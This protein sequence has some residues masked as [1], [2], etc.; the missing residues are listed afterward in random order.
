[1]S[2]NYQGKNDGWMYIFQLRLN[3]AGKFWAVP[4]K[5]LTSPNSKVGPYPI[6]WLDKNHRRD[7]NGRPCFQGGKLLM[8]F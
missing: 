2:T 4:K 6:F 8:K 7:C 5:S 3:E 1:M